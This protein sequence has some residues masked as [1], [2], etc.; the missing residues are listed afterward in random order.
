MAAF[1]F[2]RK[3]GVCPH[4]LPNIYIFY[5]ASSSGILVDKDEQTQ[6]NPRARI[7]ERIDRVIP[8]LTA[9]LNSSSIPYPVTA[10]V[11]IYSVE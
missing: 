4:I 1:A 3:T 2:L 6:R 5:D 9:L 7:Q 10:E 8:L 11:S